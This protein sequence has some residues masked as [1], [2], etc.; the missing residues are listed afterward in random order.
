LRLWAFDRVYR[1]RHGIIA[2]V[3]EA[4]RGPLAGPVVAAAVVFPSEVFIR[5]IND[6]KK[7]TPAAREEFFP[8]ICQKAIAFGIGIAQVEEI[9]QLN[10]YQATI[11]AMRRALAQLS[12][13][14]A[15][16]LLDGLPC[17]T[18]PIPHIGV[19]DGDALSASIAAASILAKVT[20]DRMME[21]LDGIY[22]AYGF[23]QH[24]GYST[25]AHLERLRSLGP[26]PIHRRSFAPVAEHF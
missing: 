5:G 7:L 18:L 10:I 14:P 4:G 19:V 8:L 15:L 25:P 26:T 22:P 16:V 13:E 23:R 9:D 17:R 6:S 3:D 11:L 2:G 20:R 12:V 24:K 1:E 21:E